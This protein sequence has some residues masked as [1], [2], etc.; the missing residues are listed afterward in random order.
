M[1]GRRKNGEGSWGTK[2][3]NGN[4]YKFYKDVNGKYF[5]GK[6]NAEI[7]AKKDA[8][9]EKH[10][11]AKKSS[12]K[13]TIVDKRKEARS[14]TFGDGILKWLKE[15]KFSEIK[16]STYDG[17]EDCIMGEIIGYDGYRLSDKQIGTIDLEIINKYYASLATVYSA[18]TIKKNYAIISQYI[19]YCNENGYFDE[20]INISKIKYP[21]EEDVEKKKKEIH[22][23]SEEDVQ[24]FCKEAK[25]INVPGFCFGKLGEY[26]YGN[27]AYLLMFIVMTGLRIGEAMAL[28]WN[29]VNRK[30]KYIIIRKT[31]VT[32]KN[33]DENNNGPKR[34]L[35]T[36]TTKTRAGERIIP[37]NESAI[38]I[39]EY[40]ESLNPDHTNNDY[41]FITKNGDRIKSSSNVR[42]TLNNIMSRAGCSVDTL[43]PHEL[44][45]TFGSLLIEK[46]VDIKVVSELLGH[47]DIKMTYNIYIHVLE[48][49]K[50]KA[51]TALD[52]ITI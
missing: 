48:K 11:D 20:T 34:I 52:K 26:T 17:Y 6:T 28:Q 36:Q 49:Q 1:A 9:Y 46:N 39:L 51:I 25:R 2:T 10:K 14:Q 18:G 4:K 47:T 13:Q 35:S 50:A 24:L 32:L 12:K 33:R 19:E 23:L 30:D 31:S 41:V 29:D 3:I 40:E 15:E 45:H 16:R 5:Y 42:R 8:Y 37:L 43:T 22:F 27:N 21:K 44:R 38:Q 7:N